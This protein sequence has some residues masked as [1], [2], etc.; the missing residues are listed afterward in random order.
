MSNWE[1]LLPAWAKTMNVG[2]ECS[3][4]I[5]AHAFISGGFLTSMLVI[6]AMQKYIAELEERRCETCRYRALERDLLDK[7]WCMIDSD[8]CAP[9]GFDKW[10]P[11]P[12]A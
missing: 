6:D 9:N 11:W 2:F 4:V 1:G 10:N 5:W 3:S 12:D 7:W 8:T